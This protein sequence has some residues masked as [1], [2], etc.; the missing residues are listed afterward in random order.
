MVC[1]KE[2]ICVMLGAWQYFTQ[3]LHEYQLREFI[4]TEHY[5]TISGIL[6]GHSGKYPHPMG[7]PLLFPSMQQWL[8]TFSTSMQAG[9]TVLRF[10]P[11]SGLDLKSFINLNHFWKNTFNFS[12]FMPPSRKA[13]LNYFIDESGNFSSVY[14]PGQ[15]HLE[16]CRQWH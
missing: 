6:S 10:F 16:S 8:E 12:S 5:R 3:C 2:N 9:R 11:P 4:C 1:S 15:E 7:K 13:S 14:A